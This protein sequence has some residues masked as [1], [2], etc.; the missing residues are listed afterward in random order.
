MRTNETEKPVI[1]YLCNYV[2]VELV[3]AAGFVPYRIF[4]DD[5]NQSVVRANNYLQ[6]NSCP[7]ARQCMGHIALGTYENL[8]GIIL[9]HTCDNMR[10][11]AEN[12][13]FYEMSPKILYTF[14]LP[15]NLCEDSGRK[16]YLRQLGELKAALEERRGRSIS[17]TELNESVDRY[18][19]LRDD[20]RAFH[21]KLVD[22]EDSQGIEDF[23]KLLRRF[24]TRTPDQTHCDL[25]RLKENGSS[26]PKRRNSRN[27][28]LIGSAMC[29]RNLE[30]IGIIH[31]NGGLV[32]D[33]Y[34]CTGLRT[35][36]M[37]IPEGTINAI[38]EAYLS[39][40]TC[41]R[42]YPTELR[43]QQ[44]EK[45]IR[46]GKVDV[47]VHYALKFCDTFSY[48]VPAL[49]DLCHRIGVPFTSIET[50]L[51]EQDRGQITTRI[52]AFFESLGAQ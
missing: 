49:K 6:R 35:L 43:E 15:R 3:H 24:F 2:P 23:Y 16:Y 32:V 48:D 26:E 37:K 38:G 25:S 41:P 9:A 28:L 50:D 42:M 12:H 27:V 19:R 4:N 5:S 29:G 14:D 18:N 40:P 21:R 10:S 17:D 11:V 51:T 8:D 44:I 52:E 39:I 45:R 36:Q 20:L 30:L 31:S 47:V 13:L 33:D 22:E 34:I 1:G 7:F 46:E